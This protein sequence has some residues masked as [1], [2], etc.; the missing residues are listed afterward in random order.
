MQLIGHDLEGTH[1]CIEGPTVDS[2]CQSKNQAMM[3]KELSI[4]IQDWI[5][6]RH[7]S[8]EVYQNVSAVL[9]IPKNTVAPLILK[10][11]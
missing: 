4:E 8:R 2:A 9:K 10:W 6:L 1:L 5:V 7:R 3:Y 11:K